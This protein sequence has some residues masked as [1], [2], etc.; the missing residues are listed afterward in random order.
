MI[1]ED[2]DRKKISELSLSIATCREINEACSSADN[3]CHKVVTSQKYL[4]LEF[5]QS[6]EPWAGNLATASVLFV[7]SNP[8]I[9][10]T[11]LNGEDYPKVDYLTASSNHPEWPTERLLDFHVNRFDQDR[12]R[13]FINK[14]AQFLCRDGYYRGSDKSQPGKGSQTFWRNAIRETKYLLGRDVDVSNDL[15]MTEV[16]H[17]KTKS[18]R[19]LNGSPVGLE[20]AQWTCAGNYLDK[21]LEVSRSTIVVATG[22]VAR[23][24]FTNPERWNPKSQWKWDIDNARFG[25]FR[26]HKGVASAHLG[27]VEVT[28]RS[29]IVCAM[30]HLSNGFGCDSFKGA[31]GIEVAGKLSILIQNIS[32]NIEKSPSSRKELFDRLSLTDS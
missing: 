24:T 18:E 29:R 14:F 9:S 13:P 22:K 1:F 19:D 16:V 6:P 12:Q 17:C 20:E 26:K 8:S 15:C 25:Q 10:E 2:K 11:V 27:I 7:S 32:Q 3:P 31:L 30:S 23:E 5:R 21:I 28:G 4:G